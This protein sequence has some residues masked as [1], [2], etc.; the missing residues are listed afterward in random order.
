MPPKYKPLSVKDLAALK[1]NLGLSN[2]QMADLFGLTPDNWRKYTGGKEPRPVSLQMLFFAAA[3]LE[4]D[5]A[6]ITRILERMRRLGAQ[7]D[8]AP[9]GER[10]P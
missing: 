6:T 2:P 4:L 3:R 8:L 7:I 10:Q 1:E 5:D 9:D